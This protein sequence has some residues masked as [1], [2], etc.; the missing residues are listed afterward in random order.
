MI[1]IMIDRNVRVAGGL[2]FSGFEHVRGA[3]PI[4][5][6][7]VQVREPEANLVAE[8]VVDHIDHD[9]RLIYIAVHWETLVPDNLP[10]VGVRIDHRQFRADLDRSIDQAL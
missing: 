7:R 3:L 10:A 6:Q 2:T 9:D 1:E 5:G 8:G 4:D